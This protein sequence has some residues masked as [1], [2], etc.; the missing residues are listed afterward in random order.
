MA[1]LP[2]VYVGPSALYEKT[3]VSGRHGSVSGVTSEV[4]RTSEWMEVPVGGEK[5][6]DFSSKGKKRHRVRKT[7]HSLTSITQVL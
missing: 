3:R 7:I 5:P 6:F 2:Q 1:L 4:C